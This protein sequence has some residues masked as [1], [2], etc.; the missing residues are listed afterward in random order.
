MLKIVKI[1]RIA[2]LVKL[3]DPNSAL[4]DA[5]EDLF[6]TSH[7][8]AATRVLFLLV[9]AFFCAHLLAC[10]MAATGDGW[11]ESYPSDDVDSSEWYWG[12]QYLVA[13]YWAFT[14]MTTGGYGDV[15]PQTDEERIFCIFAMIIGVA[16][17]SC[18]RRVPTPS[19]R[20]DRRDV[21]CIGTSSRRWRAWSRA[22]TR[23]RRSTANAWSS[24]GRG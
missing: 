23:S 18:R 7:W 6:L 20:E 5:M 22:P 1:V 17:Y 13:L 8:A 15:T 24:S 19:T 9:L 10:S 21:V 14:T 4:A 12:R 16:F 3:T 11:Y 2:K